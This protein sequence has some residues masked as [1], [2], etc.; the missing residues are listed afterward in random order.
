MSCLCH[1]F[2]SRVHDLSHSPPHRCAYMNASTHT[3]THTCTHAHTR[4][5]VCM[6]TYT[7]AHT[8]YICT[9]IA[10]MSSH[11][12]LCCWPGASTSALF[13]LYTVTQSTM[14]SV[15]PNSCRPLTPPKS[16][17]PCSMLSHTVLSE[18]CI[19]RI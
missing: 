8:M 6:H 10:Q 3:H 17:L 2:Y 4:T 5:Y 15:Y 19:R 11:L 14:M 13:H 7:H 1:I 9:H 18:S 12:K 16:S